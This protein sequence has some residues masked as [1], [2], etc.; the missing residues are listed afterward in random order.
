MEVIAPMFAALGFFAM[1]GFIVWNANR[2][3]IRKVEE[4]ASV[5]NR[6]VDKFAGAKEFT[7]FIQ[8]SD[9]QRFLE[10]L[11]TEVRVPSEAAL[12]SIRTGIVLTF[13]GAG[14]FAGSPVVGGNALVVFG[15]ITVA[16]GLGFLSSG[17]VT[18]W[19]A[20]S[21]NQSENSAV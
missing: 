6:I 1:I 18:R 2:T 8:S 4:R 19:L 5:F 14:F 10:K 21:W 7:D 13:L 12:G 16:L 15:S 20:R 11:G 3:R 9:G 17:F